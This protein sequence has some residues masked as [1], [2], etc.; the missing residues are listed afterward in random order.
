MSE[1]DAQGCELHTIRIM[2][3]GTTVT[4]PYETAGDELIAR[5]CLVPCRLFLSVML[6]IASLSSM[7]AGFTSN[8]K[9]FI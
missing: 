8:A 3:I 1:G 4:V 9:S 7:V 6:Q 2:A 5:T